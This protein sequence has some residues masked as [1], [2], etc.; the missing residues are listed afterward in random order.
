MILSP[1]NNGS[2]SKD[3][4]ISFSGTGHDL[5]DGVLGGSSLVWTDQSSTVLGT[6]S[7]FQRKLDPGD[8]EITLTVTDSTNLT[9]SASVIIIVPNN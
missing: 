5:E 9:G 6:G 8:Y 7:T 3:L 1:I 2:Y 4:Q